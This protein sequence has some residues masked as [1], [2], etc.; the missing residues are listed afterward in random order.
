MKEFKLQGIDL[1]KYFIRGRFIFRKINIEL[2][3][4]QI[5]GIAGH[6]GS[7]KTTLL[8]ILSG[9]IPASSGTIDFSIDSIKHKREKISDH[10]G[11]VSPYLTLYEEFTPIEHFRIFSK[12]KGLDYDEK[13]IFSLLSIFKLTK[14]KDEQIKTF[15]SGMK[16]RIKYISALAGIP[17]ILFLDEPF[18]NLDTDGIDSVKE[19]IDE[20]KKSGGGIIIASNDEREKQLCE[21]V[22][23]I[24]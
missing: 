1:S 2:N 17:E 9:I 15:S 16:Q 21:N 22:V 5:V 12:I 19:I 3:S 6:N 10:L 11:F 18:T 14:R 20:H 13:R 4:N 8:K 23:N 7:G 24:S